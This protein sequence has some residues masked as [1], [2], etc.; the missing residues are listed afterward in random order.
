MRIST[1][2]MV[3]VAL[4]AMAMLYPNW[5][6]AGSITGVNPQAV[7]FAVDNSGGTVPASL[8]HWRGWRGGYSWGW[9]YPSGSYYY[10]PHHY[11]SYGYY[12]YSYYNYYPYRSSYYTY[13]PSGSYW[14]I[15]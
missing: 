4:L 3:G 5:A 12:P 6:N 13:Y 1:Y 15:Y 7:S 2:M 9:N 14:R 10:R 11:R 8:V